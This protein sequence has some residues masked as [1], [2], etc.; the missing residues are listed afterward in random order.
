MYIL[1]GLVVPP[2]Q[3]PWIKTYPCTSLRFC[4]T[5]G[6]RYNTIKQYLAGIRYHYAA[7]NI[8]SPLTSPSAFG[9]LFTLPRGIKKS[10][11]IVSRCRLP[12]TYQIL[13]GM[14]SALEKGFMGNYD[15]LMMSAACSMAFSAFL[16]AGELTILNQ[17]Y[18][19]T[20]KWLNFCTNMLCRTI[21]LRYIAQQLTKNLCCTLGN[22]STARVAEL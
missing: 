14:L 17:T 15:G 11:N 20:R 9:R 7:F 21:Y 3:P 4:A 1:F 10:Q 8:P 6:L 5:K 19:A 22:V 18:Y 16:S 13:S 2:P 12:I